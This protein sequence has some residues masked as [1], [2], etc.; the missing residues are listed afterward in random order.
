M[1]VLVKSIVSFGVAASVHGGLMWG[2]VGLNPNITIA[3]T[4]LSGFEVVELPSSAASEQPEEVNEIVEPKVEEPD[5]VLDPIV[6]VKPVVKPKPKPKPKPNPKPKPKPKPLLTPKPVPKP[7]SFKGAESVA[8][9]PAYVPP[10]QHASYLKNPK[11]AYPTQARKRGMEGRVVLRVF[12]RSD[13]R[14]KSVK[15]ENSSGYGLLDRAARVAVIR[16]RFA[17]A[18]RSGRVVDAEVLIPFDF[19]LTS[20]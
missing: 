13:G 1:T 12:V 11:P 5:V 2:L 20:G 14:V 16:W 7:I 10:S 15:L 3:P 8:A 6:A 19:L 18:T 17:P 9:Q 4:P